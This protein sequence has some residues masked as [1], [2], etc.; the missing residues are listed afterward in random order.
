VEFIG[1]QRSGNMTN[2]Y[3]EGHPSAVITKVER[4]ADS[5]YN[6]PPNVVLLMA[7]TEDVIKGEDL[8]AAPERLGHLIDEV[9][10]NYPRAAVVVA[11]LPPID[12]VDFNAQATTFNAAIS[13]IVR[14]KV[15]EGR[16]IS[17]VKMSDYMTVDD[18]QDGLYPT[19]RGYSLMAQ[20]WYDGIKYA[21]SKSWLA[22]PVVRR[23][24]AMKRD[25]AATTCS[26]S[27][28]PS[29][30]KVKDVTSKAPSSAG[31][32]STNVK[33][34]VSEAP[35]STAQPT[36]TLTSTTTVTSTVTLKFHTQKKYTT[37]PKPTPTASPTPCTTSSTPLVTSTAAA[38]TTTPISIPTP[39]PTPT[40]ITP[41]PVNNTTIPII[42]SSSPSPASIGLPSPQ[43]STPGGTPTP[44]PPTSAASRV[45]GN[46]L[47]MAAGL[48]FFWLSGMAI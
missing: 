26:S 10:K 36:T 23:R 32:A 34:L 9:V 39:T 11:E 24:K 28:A 29:A 37:V 43:S 15:E 46:F 45:G 44:P 17:T 25:A 48:L 5:S 41:P 40:E 27:K 22:P 12:D 16:R 35:S 38:N 14:P 33:D 30:T 13:G 20:A 47:W 2:N 6:E 42:P 4:Y 7:G 8:S 3:N 31:P 18:L 1:T 21:E 19:D